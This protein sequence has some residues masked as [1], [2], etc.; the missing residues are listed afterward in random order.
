MPLVDDSGEPVRIDARSCVV[1][2]IIELSSSIEPDQAINASPAQKKKVQRIT[3]LVETPT[4]L[5]VDSMAF[6]PSTQ[7]PL[8]VPFHERLRRCLNQLPESD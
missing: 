6:A 1:Q 2:R 3:T 8:R 4:N 7:P 5:V